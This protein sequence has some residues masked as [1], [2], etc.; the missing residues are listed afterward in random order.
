MN[1][2][3]S[4]GNLKGRRFSYEKSSE[5]RPTMEST[6]LAIF[7]V[8]DSRPQHIISDSIFVDLYAGTGIMGLEALSRG[9]KKVF[10]VEKNRY[11]CKRISDNLNL[12]DL[13]HKSEVVCGPV[14]SFLSY[15]NI[16]ASHIFADPPYNFK[17]YNK[18]VEQ[19]ELNQ[20][21]NNNGII[22]LETSSKYKDFIYQQELYDCDERVKGDTKI[23]FLMR[24]TNYE[25]NISR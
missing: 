4:G 2:R 12:L 16:G 22:V 8:L 6:R 10:F 15:G 18:L 11:L 19:I 25:R 9:A 21:L 3:I 17:E 5:L 13:E 23:N 24:K 20:I 7:S 14:N 1:I